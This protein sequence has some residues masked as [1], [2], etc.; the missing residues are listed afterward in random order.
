MTERAPARVVHVITRMI[1]G[2]AQENTL[3]TVAGLKESPRYDVT[4]V[5]GPAIGPEG[6]LLDAARKCGVRVIVVPEMRREVNPWLDGVALAS[7]LAILRRLRPAIVHTHSSKAGILAR[8]AARLCRVPT[9]VHT[10]HGLPFHPYQGWLANKLFVWLERGAAR[11]TDQI[12]TV[13]DAMIEQAVAAR[14]ASR[15]RFRTIYSGMDVDAFLRRDWDVAAI[16]ARLGLTPDDLVVGKIARLASLKGYE[17][18]IDV[19]PAVVEE[20]PRA[21]FLFVGDGARRHELERRVRQLGITG[22][23][24]FAGLVD[25]QK[26]PE[27]IAAMDLVVHASLRE[28]LARVLPQ[29]LISGKPVVSFDVDGAREVVID[30]E[31]G[32]LVEPESRPRLL[33]AMRA[34]LADPQRRAALGAAGC[35][36]CAE[37]FRAGVMVSRIADLYEELLAQKGAV[38]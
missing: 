18:V 4:L 11:W 21:K 25:A 8:L 15:S 34:L 9:I 22:R 19:A 33:D 16:R 17:H 20:F 2:G 38:G 37:Q 5:T 6:E 26:I 29:A 32:Y 23:V 12:V 35:A 31:T 10:I 13:A 14:V 27:M 28:G 30:G 24:V 7:L 3:I 1:L 36:R